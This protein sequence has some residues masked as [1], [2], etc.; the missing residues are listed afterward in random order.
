MIW[1]LFGVVGF[2]SHLGKDTKALQLQ[3]FFDAYIPAG[4]DPEKNDI[5]TTLPQYLYLNLLNGV[6]FLVQHSFFTLKRLKSYGMSHGS[7][8]LFTAGKV[9]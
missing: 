1:V 6:L 4:A 8:R 9:L 3:W 5:A 7:A 2:I